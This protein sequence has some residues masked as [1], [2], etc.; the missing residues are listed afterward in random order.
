MQ[1]NGFRDL[2]IQGFYST[3]GDVI[4]S[5][6][7]EPVLSEA[8]SFDRLTGY[9]SVHSIVSVARGMQ[10]L[11]KNNG[12]MRLVIGIHDVPAELISAMSLGQLLPEDL[13]NKY[14]NRL[15]S[16]I[17]LLNDESQ[18]S[19]IAGLAWMMRLGI[20]E[21][22]VA[23]PRNSRGIF[24]QKRMIFRDAH[25][26][27]IAGTGSLNETMGS[28]SNVEEMQFNLSWESGFN[29]VNLLVDSFD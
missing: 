1:E 22:K 10:G 29:V 2:E 7:I 14:K 21:V 6:F 28:R 26:N 16:E 9:F 17:E 25:G 23:A 27:V 12:K 11:Y 24:H 13:V 20:L 18:K 3:T 5:E 8:I 19:A 15:Y 4:A